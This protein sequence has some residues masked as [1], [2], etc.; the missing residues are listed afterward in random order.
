ML[1]CWR[2][3]PT[4]DGSST[5]ASCPHTRRFDP[6]EFESTAYPRLDQNAL[7]RR[8]LFV[9]PGARIG[10]PSELEWKKYVCNPKAA[11]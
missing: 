11:P 2:N 7:V 10:E 1:G 6:E 8:A 4:S 9:V 5:S 3:I